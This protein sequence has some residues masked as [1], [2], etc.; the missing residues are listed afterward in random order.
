MKRER[1]AVAVDLGASSGRFAAG[2][3]EEG[4][5]R[6]EIVEQI[7]HAPRF[8]G[9]RWVWDLDL[10][11]GLCRRAIDY[12]GAHFHRATAGIDSWGVDHG[13]LDREGRLMGPPV[14]YRD[15]SH[16]AAMAS[17]EGEQ[18]RLYSLTGIQRQPFNTLCQLIARRREQPDLPEKAT[19]LILPDLLGYLLT[20]RRGY[21]LTQAS[22][23]QLLGL[24][25]KWCLEA[26]AIAGWPAP[27]AQPVPPG[28]V[29]GQV[30]DGVDLVRVG[31]HDTASAVR[32]LGGLGEDEA[33]LNVGTWSIVGAVLPEAITSAAAE[34]GN[35]SNE[36]AVDGRVRFL[37]NVP[38]F[39]VVNR[40]HDELGID[41]DV[42]AWLE[43]ALPGQVGRF[44]L[45]DPSLYNP[46]SMPKAVSALL[47]REPATPAEWAGVALDSLVYALA[48]QVQELAEVLG[49]PIRRLRVGG[50]GSRSAPFCRSL[51][52]RTGLP[53]SKG[54]AEAT[55][56]GNLLVQLESVP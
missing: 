7:A 42:A 9:G 20:G 5:L 11:L 50:G 24:D 43:S 10:L 46:D 4:E 55:V 27:N 34:H 23:T 31:S 39:Y 2:W 3:L 32:G 40:L 16:E 41:S 47:G 36:L 22:T 26:F 51:A 48:A 8:E 53:V 25:R 13:F 21:E 37:K 56:V 35:W 14:S 15:P 45:F 52:D 1:G 19:W 49:R 12:A 33:F 28:G 38:G 29:I 30:A 54:P 44:D 6:F 18:A 17:I